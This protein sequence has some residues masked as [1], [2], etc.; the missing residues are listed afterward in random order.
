[1]L[2][3]QELKLEFPP[4]ITDPEED[5]WEY[6]NNDFVESGYTLPNVR[7]LDLF[8]SGPAAYNAAV[9]FNNARLPESKTLK[10]TSCYNRNASGAR[11]FPS[12]Y[13]MLAISASCPKNMSLLNT[14]MST[15]DFLLC[16]TEGSAS[17]GKVNMDGRLR[18]RLAGET[19]LKLG[20]SNLL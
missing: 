8:F 10:F 1:M 19:I 6:V 15:L 17:L 4:N 16:L 9:F 3:V 7:S 18:V 20:I 13:N 11:M 5:P 14:P 12:I 2:G